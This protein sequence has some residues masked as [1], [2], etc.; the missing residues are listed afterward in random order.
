MRRNEFL[1]D[2]VNPSPEILSKHGGEQ[3]RVAFVRSLLAK[4]EVLLLD[5]IS[6]VLDEQDTLVLEQ[7]IEKR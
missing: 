7:L 3:Q 5:E 6:A 1:S 4:P 2:A